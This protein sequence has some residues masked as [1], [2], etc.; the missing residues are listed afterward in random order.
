V[1]DRWLF[2]VMREACFGVKRFDDFH[3]RTR[4]ARNILADRLQHLVSNGLLQRHRYQDAPERFE[5]RLVEKGK[6]L[7][8]AILVLLAWGDRW[9]A[10]KKGPPLLLTHRLCGKDFHP[11]LVCSSCGSEVKSREVTYSETPP[12]GGRMREEKLR[13]DA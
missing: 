6:S 5:Y 10:R 3:E 8:Q 11:I 2:L 13:V 9:Q 1:A 12:A 4:I 7:Y